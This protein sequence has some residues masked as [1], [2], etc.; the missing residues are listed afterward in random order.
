MSTQTIVRL[1]VGFT[2]AEKSALLAANVGVSLVLVEPGA[3]VEPKGGPHR[4]WWMGLLDVLKTVGDAALP[5]VLSPLL[6]T[7]AARLLDMGIDSAERLLSGSP[8]IERWPI[9]KM[10]LER[11]SIADPVT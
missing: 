6:G 1:P 7:G 3:V 2:P 9:E 4:E 10:R 5:I 11:E 8:T